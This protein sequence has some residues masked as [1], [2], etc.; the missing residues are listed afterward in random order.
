MKVTRIAEDPSAFKIV[1][2]PEHP[3]ANEE[4]YVELPNIDMV[5]EIADSMAA[6][7]AVTFEE[8]A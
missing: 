5:K 3:D 2:D 4:G 8:Y 1:Y 6:T 7:Q